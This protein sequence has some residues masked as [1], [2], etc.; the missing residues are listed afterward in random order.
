MEK[1]ILVLDD[2]KPLLEIISLFLKRKG[3]EVTC[4][5]SGTKALECFKEEFDKGA[6]YTIAILDVSIPGDLGAREIAGPMKE[7]YPDVRII[8]T[9]GDS[10]EEAVQD[11][12]IH[13]FSASLKKPFRAADIER[14]IEEACRNK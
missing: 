6:P 7:I 12:L 13:G 5:S 10:V 1:K 9:S 8:I 14:S 3:D 2:E 4:F 11:P